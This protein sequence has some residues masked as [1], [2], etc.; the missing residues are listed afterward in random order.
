[1]KWL[2]LVTILLG[3]AGGLLILRQDILDTRATLAWAQSQLL[4]AET[5]LQSTQTNLM[6]TEA[7]WAETRRN[8]AAAEI[9]LETASEQANSF[10]V[11]LGNLEVN[12]DRLVTGYGYVYRDP[13]YEMVTTFLAD[14]NTSARSYDIDSYKCTDFSADVKAN[15]SEE[16]IRCAYVNIDYPDGNGHAI[17]AF[18]TTD[19]GLVFFEPQTDEEV[20]LRVN[21]RFYESVIPRSG[22]YYLEPEHDD[23]VLRFTVIW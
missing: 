8:L 22:Y 20:N 6:A 14:D 4:Q 3:L 5:D 13:T 10:E 19:E 15:A 16:G 7:A 11:A 1:M 2:I 17:V 21:R 9:A 23:T 12:Y 18:N